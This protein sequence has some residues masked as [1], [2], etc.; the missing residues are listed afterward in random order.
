MRGTRLR[1][2]RLFNLHLSSTAALPIIFPTS[3][4]ELP[5]DFARTLFQMSSLLPR[6]IREEAAAEGY[7]VSDDSRGFVCNADLDVA[8]R[9]ID[10]GT[11]I[12]I[13][14]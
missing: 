4:V 6:R 2:N 13:L 11:R 10:I 8:I 14:R 5:D 3:S 1:K 9:F 12:G 7:T